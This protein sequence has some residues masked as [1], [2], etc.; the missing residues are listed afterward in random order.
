[1]DLQKL[2]TQNPSEWPEASDSDAVRLMW[3]AAALA[4]A[5]CLVL[6]EGAEASASVLTQATAHRS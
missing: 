2:G 4:E 3:I 6:K 1:M 5:V